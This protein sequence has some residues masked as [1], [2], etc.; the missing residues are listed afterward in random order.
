MKLR[1]FGTYDKK[2]L[3]KPTLTKWV[4]MKSFKSKGLRSSTQ[5]SHI[6]RLAESEAPFF[7]R[8]CEDI[9]QSC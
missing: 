4:F 2:K 5:V 6:S 7:A 8:Y 1:I 3:G 9:I